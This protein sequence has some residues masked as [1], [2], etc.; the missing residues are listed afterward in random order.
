MDREKIIRERF[1][2]F[3]ALV[4]MGYNTDKKIIDLKEEELALKPNINRSDLT[5]AMRIRKSLI[6]RNLVTFL[7][8]LEG[9]KPY[10]ANKR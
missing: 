10:I 8:G 9:V 3:Q 5:I 2:V 6:E 1:R 7:N 4:R